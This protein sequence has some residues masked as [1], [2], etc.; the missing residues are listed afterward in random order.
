[1]LLAL[2][3]QSLMAQQWEVK[4][5]SAK[6]N[7]GLMGSPSTQFYGGACNQSRTWGVL[8]MLRFATLMLRPSIWSEAQNKLWA[9]IPMMH[10]PSKIQSIAVIGKMKYARRSLPH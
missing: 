8:S 7:K 1:M 3:H 6:R 4:C 9:P 5:Y 2:P 10:M